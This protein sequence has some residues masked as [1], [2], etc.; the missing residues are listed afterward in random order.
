[1]RE[2][3]A[4]RYEELYVHLFRQPQPQRIQIRSS[5][6]DIL[7]P[8]RGFLEGFDLTMQTQVGCPA[9]CF[10]C[11]V[12]AGRMLTPPN[13][14]GSRGERW[15][16]EVRRKRDV[17]KKLRY[18]LERGHLAGRT[19]YWSGVTDPYATPAQETRGIWAILNAAPAEQRPRRIVIQ[20]RFRADRDAEALAQ[21][22][23]A[24]R[25]ADGGPAVVVSASIGTDQDDFIRAWERAAPRFEQRMDAIKR[26][27][28]AGVFVVPTLS[29]FGFWGD[30]SG[31]LE[32]FRSWG[33]PFIT[34]L[35]FKRN[36]PSSNTP[37]RFL[38]Y[39]E[40]NYP[41]LL[42]AHWQ[43][44]QLHRMRQGYGRSRVLPGKAGFSALT[45]PHLV[46]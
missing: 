9:G 18:H 29:P 40:R 23:R 10:F 37:P 25:A 15:G 39:L 13:L 42:D 41:T 34:V 7:Q 17:H 31:T 30:L 20:T 36:T 11:Y 38:T 21:Y 46:L 8:A 5:Q 19:V 2:P 44:E 28:E 35:F 32:A 27:R 22:S 43:A 6:A 33:I 4:P 3:D 14:R 16:F 24:T 12:P 26:L 1:M 45:A